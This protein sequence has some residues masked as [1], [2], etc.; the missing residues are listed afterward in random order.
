MAPDVS[1]IVYLLLGAVIYQGVYLVI[2]DTHPYARQ[3]GAVSAAAAI[4][5]GIVYS[6]GGLPNSA[7]AVPAFFGYCGAALLISVV[8][9]LIPF[10]RI[11]L[12]REASKLAS[13]LEDWSIL[14]RVQLPRFTSAAVHSKEAQRLDAEYKE[15]FG[16]KIVRLMKPLVASD[17]I[18]EDLRDTWLRVPTKTSLDLASTA[19]LGALFFQKYGSDEL[20]IPIS[21]QRF[22]RTFIKSTT[23]YFVGALGFLI[24]LFIVGEI[25]P[26]P[27]QP[28]TVAANAPSPSATPHYLPVPL[29]LKN[30]F[31][32]DF[33]QMHLTQD[34]KFTSRNT[35]SDYPITYQLIWDFDAKTEFLAV[36]IP[37]TTDAFIAAK[38]VAMGYQGMID[39]LDER[40]KASASAPGES[41]AT[42][43]TDLT[44]SGRIFVYYEGDLTLQQMA[45]L[46]Q[47][48]T[49]RKLAVEFRGLN[50]QALRGN[51]K[52]VAPDAH[53]HTLKIGGGNGNSN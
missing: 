3:I 51:E 15:K 45:S 32:T 24:V 23:L 27:N 40:V 38:A 28:L 44:F 19:H 16:A 33:P 46:E 18:H 49:E 47:L 31:D 37:R 14:A 50:Y 43:S 7:L 25:Q 29:T 48:F 53:P 41:A 11:S 52:R 26:A 5:V 13:E 36:F 20:P 6:R 39:L 35:G 1:Q 42:Q 30:L 22:D 21:T 9:A 2:P 34:F 10:S 8:L 17:K 4:V 12:R